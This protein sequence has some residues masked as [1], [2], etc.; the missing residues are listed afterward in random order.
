LAPAYYR[1]NHFHLAYH[2]GGI[3]QLKLEVHWDLQEDLSLA[4]PD[5]NEIWGS[6]VEMQVAGVQAL[7]LGLEDLLLYLCLHLDKH[8]FYHRFLVAQPDVNW[9]SLAVDGASRLVWFCDIWEVLQR[10]QQDVDWARCVDKARRWGIEGAVYC[11]LYFVQR[12]FGPSMTERALAELRPPR[13]R[14]Y[15]ACFYRFVLQQMPATSTGKGGRSW[16][17]RQ[18]MDLDQRLQFR[19]AKLIGL[20]GHILPGR[21]AIERHYGVTGPSVVLYYLRHI[22]QAMARS[23]IGLAQLV[24]YSIQKR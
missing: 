19:P 9:C 22:V 13:M 18:L 21:E 4:R 14:W 11:S 1:R 8:G 2:G 12:L 15:E 6:A 20:P 16:L 3:A 23:S 10:H 5:L 7:G 17:S 24:Y